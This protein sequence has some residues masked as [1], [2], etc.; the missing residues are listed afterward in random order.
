MRTSIS[1]RSDC[2]LS[3]SVRCSTDKTSDDSNRGRLALASAADADESAEVPS[4]AVSS[5]LLVP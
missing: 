4:G 2:Q 1:N 3:T 5:D